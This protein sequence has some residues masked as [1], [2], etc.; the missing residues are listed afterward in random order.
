[1]LF[2]LVMLEV[3][4]SSGGGRSLSGAQTH[5]GVKL[6]CDVDRSLLYRPPG[7]VCLKLM[8]S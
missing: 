2:C 5:N 3:E 7:E 8:T 1:M 4:V 6:S